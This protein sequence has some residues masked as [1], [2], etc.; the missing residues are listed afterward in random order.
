MSTLRAVLNE[1]KFASN[2]PI[3]LN[4]EHVGRRSAM[5]KKNSEAIGT[6]KLGANLFQV[7]ATLSKFA[8]NEA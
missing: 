7:S 4:R 5:F 2:F 1:S 3:Y 6:Q 8:G